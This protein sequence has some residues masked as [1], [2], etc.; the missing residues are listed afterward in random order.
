MPIT[1]ARFR[2]HCGGSLSLRL[3]AGERGLGREICDPRVQKAGLGLTGEVDSVHEGRIQVLGRTE[4]DY[5]DGQPPDRVSRIAER[6]FSREIACAVVSQDLPV[7]DR[8]S[9][10]ADRR[11]IPLLVSPL[12][13]AELIGKLLPCLARLFAETTTVHGVLLD[14][15]GVGVLLQGKSGVGKS[16]CALDLILRGHRIVSD[17]LIYLERRGPETL[18]GRGGELAR[19][20]MEIRGLGIIDIRELFGL[21]ATL[22]TK[23]VELVI[24]LEEWDPGKEYDR[25]GTEDRFLELLGVRLPSRLIPVSPGRNLATIVEVAVRNFLLRGE[26]VHSA[27]D[28]AARHGESLRDRGP[29]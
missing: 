1:V 13:T 12:P 3:L 10:A 11:G 15:L 23:K 4:L 14:V 2:D 6:F 7:P 18:L 22:D 8:L 9:E 19:Y 24:H 29:G 20:H 21:S 17:D 27:R 16:E 5:L 26:G 25:L 28:L